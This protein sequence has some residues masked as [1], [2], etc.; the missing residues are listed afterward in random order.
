M[1]ARLGAVLCA[2]ACIFGVA[3]FGPTYNGVVRDR[4]TA[5][6]LAKKNCGEY[7]RPFHALLHAKLQGDKWTVS[8]NAPGT[9]AQAII[10][11]KTGRPL[12]C[13]GGLSVY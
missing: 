13:R 8:V 5:I 11:A 3:G 7:F 12:V 9:W 10:D 2:A 1:R 4:A 6:T